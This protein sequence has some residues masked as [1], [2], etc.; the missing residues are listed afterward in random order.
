MTNHP[1]LTVIVGIQKSG[2]T[3]LNRLLQRTDAFLPIGPGEA[4]A[5]WGN[6]PPFTPVADPVG[7]LRLERGEDFGHE[8]DAE[9]ATPEVVRLLRERLQ[10]VQTTSKTPTVAFLA[11]SPYHA[12][13]LPWLR[14]VFPQA[15]IVATMRRPQANIFSLVK[16]HVPHR[17][18]GLPPDESGWWG[19]KP[20]GWR[21]LLDHDPIRRCTSQWVATNE[22]LLGTLREGDLVVDYATLCRRPEEVLRAVI[23]RS[24]GEPGEVGVIVEELSS[25][26]DEYR[27]GSTLRSKNRMFRE[28]GDFRLP[29]DEPIELP[30]FDQPSL[31]VIEQ[32]T[33][34]LWT[35]MRRRCDDMTG[36]EVKP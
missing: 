27:T 10:S 9:Q 28:T 19:V 7:R 11:K 20:A 29:A 22:R 2:T 24:G 5:F 23:R 15:T 34:S 26:D 13:R 31:E 35:R 4:D 36:C 16:K 25:R 32:A 1:P 17:G 3:L 12:V 21:S 6:D 8:L 14:V 33:G 18:R 30:P